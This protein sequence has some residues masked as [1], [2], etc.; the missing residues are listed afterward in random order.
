[1]IKKEEKNKVGRPKLADDKTKKESL[2]VCLFVFIVTIIVAVLGYNI[3]M[4]CFNSDDLVSTV[5]NDHVNS[6]V[7]KNDMIDCGPNVTYMKYKL[8][9]QKEVELSKKDESI[10][11]KIGK[12]N[13]INVCFKTDKTNLVCNEFGPANRPFE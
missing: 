6:C 13:K 5:Y 4:I 11:V 7:L 3:F 1:M 10:E 2:F 9:N 8:D 12:Y